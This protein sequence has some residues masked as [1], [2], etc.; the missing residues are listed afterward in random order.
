MYSSY[1]NTILKKKCYLS[2]IIFFVF[3]NKRHWIFFLL[4]TF[5]IFFSRFLQLYRQ[6]FSKKKITFFYFLKRYK[7][8]FNFIKLVYLHKIFLS[9]DTYSYSTIYFTLK[10][11]FIFFKLFLFNIYHSHFLNSYKSVSYIRNKDLYSIS[12]SN[13]FKQYDS[14]SS[15]I[16]NKLFFYYLYKKDKQ[17]F[18]YSYTYFDSSL[19]ETYNNKLLFNKDYNF[20]NLLFKRDNIFKRNKFSFFY[21]K[22]IYYNVNKYFINSIC[23]SSIGKY[24]FLL[25]NNILNTKKYYFFFFYNCFLMNFLFKIYNNVDFYKKKE[26]YFLYI[27]DYSLSD[28]YKGIFSSPKSFL[29]TFINECK[30]H[31]KKGKL[32]S[33]LSSK[34]T[35][36]SYN[37]FSFFIYKKLYSIIKKKK[38]FNSIDWYHICN[39]YYNKVLIL[40]NLIL[41]LFMTFFTNEVSYDS[42]KYCLLYKE[43]NYFNLIKNTSINK[44]NTMYEKYNYNS[45]KKDNIY[46][47]KISIIHNN[48]IKNSTL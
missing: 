14:L 22:P 24:S 39:Y 23:S 33:A 40:K 12:K 29:I 43:L 15:F 16:K 7:K 11:F 4:K 10:R 28:S 8:V 47:K 45:I 31:L 30:L 38:I 34:S 25:L 9:F 35:L 21:N 27:I 17:L 19:C 18:F 48:L 3:L 1:Y 41:L 2:Y 26:S 37:I 42:F 44:S 5:Y 36:F 13:Y 32:M 6:K 46:L 20:L